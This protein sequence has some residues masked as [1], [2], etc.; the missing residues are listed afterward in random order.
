MEC[1]MVF[2]SGI[3]YSG[4]IDEAASRS[5]ICRA[6]SSIV[7]AGLAIAVLYFS[8][9]TGVFA[10]Q[11]KI[12]AAEG[13]SWGYLN[14]L[15]GEKSPGAADLWGD[16]TKDK[17]TGMLVRFNKG[18]SSPPHIH[19]ITYRGIVIEG[20]MHNAHPNDHKSW[21]P[22]GSFWTQPAGQNHVTA[23]NADNNLIYLE[24]D[25][26]PYLVEPSEKRF[27]NG[28]KPINVHSNNLV[29]LTQKQS[30]LLNT[31][32]ISISHLWKHNE[33]ENGVVQGALLKIS[34]NFEAKIE[35]GEEVLRGV[36]ISGNT[37]ISRDNKKTQQLL[38]PGSYFESE[39]ALNIVLSTSVETLVYVRFSE[40]FSISEIANR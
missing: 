19:N 40:P 35:T 38:S 6:W 3:N 15:R 37:S 10:G 21:L 5:V 32:G 9:A 12:T 23:A 28:E 24:I 1:F 14:P 8:S 27:D 2:D 39:G 31:Q 34:P 11:L 29:W 16:R 26:G 22:T 33:T 17:K 20:L 13:V 7:R 18:F 25:E 4:V 30:A 36:V